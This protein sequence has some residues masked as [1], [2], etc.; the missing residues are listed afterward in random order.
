[1]F[2]DARR[3]LLEGLIDYAGLFPPASLSMADAVAEYRSIRESPDSWIAARFIVPASRL[4][5]LAS[6]LAPTM[7]RG[8]PTWPIAVILDGD[9]GS[10]VASTQVMSAEMGSAVQFVFA[11]VPLPVDIDGPDSVSELYGFVDAVCAISPTIVPFFEIPR[12]PEWRAR[13]GVVLPMIA[14]ASAD[15]H[16]LLGAKLRTGGTTSEAFPSSAEVADFVIG[17]AASGVPFKATAGLHH[18]YH[19]TWH[20][21]GVQRHGF[22]NLLVA[23]ALADVGASRDTIIAALDVTADSGFPVGMTGISVGDVLLDVPSLQRIRTTRF[24]SYGSCSFDEPT[25][26]LR[27]LGLLPKGPT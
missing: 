22:I 18:P 6:V 23:V 1:M 12:T 10:A 16:R 17:C 13:L 14:A 7:R 24:P 5:E 15:R 9:L 2:V 21:L 4:V 25:D 8:E 11:E 19:H 26:E 3:V 20:E 27:A